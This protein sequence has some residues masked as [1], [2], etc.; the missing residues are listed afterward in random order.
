MREI[1]VEVH[2]R[3]KKVQAI[4]AIM[5][6]ITMETNDPTM[7][8]TA[9]PYMRGE[10]MGYH[11]TNDSGRQVNIG[12]SNTCGEEP[13]L[14]LGTRS[15]FGPEF[16]DVLEQGN[17]SFSKPESYQEIAYEALDWLVKGVK[18]L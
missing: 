18:P 2:P 3:F 13:Y 16:S 5:E 6:T 14:W 17:A 8:L 11:I 15:D 10:T 7:E 12:C 1:K 9:K 4:M